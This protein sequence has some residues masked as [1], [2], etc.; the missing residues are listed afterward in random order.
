ML[1]VAMTMSSSQLD[2]ILFSQMYYFRVWA[3]MVRIWKC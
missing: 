2:H 1:H 3:L